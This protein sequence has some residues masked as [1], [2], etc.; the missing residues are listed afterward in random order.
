MIIK[1]LLRKVIESSGALESYSIFERPIFII[2]PPRSGSTLLFEFLRRFDGV[3]D[4]GGEADYIWWSL[5][6]YDR[7]AYPSDYLGER[8]ATEEKIGMIRARISRDAVVRYLKRNIMKLQMRGLIGGHPMRYVDKTIANCFHLEILDRAFPD[9][10]YVFL[11]RE[12]RAN[13]SSMM[14]GWPY[15]DRFGKAQLTPIVRSVNTGTIRHW[16]YPAPP[17]WHDVISRPLPEICAWSWKQHIECSLEFFR[18][19]LKRVIWVRYEDLVER[20]INAINKLACE[21]DLA[22]SSKVR[23][24]AA[25]LPLSRTTLSAPNQNKWMA[26]NYDDVVSILPLIAHTAR[27]IGYEVS[28]DP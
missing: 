18:R 21:L 25:K 27:K 10:Q 22:E 1:T 24:Y 28:L 4:L 2:S 17:G 13:I 19:R 12:P 3:C 11:V 7:E 20:R 14:E 15:V 8:D 16:T 26:R 9:A 6:P 5:F 23:Q